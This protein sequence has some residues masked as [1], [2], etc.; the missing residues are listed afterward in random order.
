MQFQTRGCRY[1]VDWSTFEVVTSIKRQAPN[2]YPDDSVAALLEAQRIAHDNTVEQ[3]A[4]VIGLAPSS[5]YKK[6]EGVTPFKVEE[7]GR[8][9]EFWKMP[10]G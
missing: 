6:V 5:W 3:M 10:P 4:D 9:A 1:G 7:V 8:C 2:R